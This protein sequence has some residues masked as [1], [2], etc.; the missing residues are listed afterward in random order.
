MNDKKASVRKASWPCWVVALALWFCL[1]ADV[2][3]AQTTNQPDNNQI[4][5]SLLTEVRLLRKTLQRTGLNTYRSQIIVSLLQRHNEKVERLTLQ[6]EELRNEIDKI[7]KTIPHF[8]EQSQVIAEQ[9][10]RET[11][12]SKR[13]RLELDYKDKKRGVENYKILLEQHREREKQLA[14]HLRA[15]QTK[16]AELE[17]RLD[18]LER[19]IEIEVNRL[20]SEEAAEES[21]KKP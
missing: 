20:H 1:A 8:A 5:Q 18:T 2:T 6:H 7:E 14:T 13:A 21:K 12:A 10:E 16:L 9:M 11:D 4:I 3:Q 19:E 17:S 15:E